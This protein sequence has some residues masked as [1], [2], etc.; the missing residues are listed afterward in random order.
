MDTDGYAKIIDMGMAKVV[1]NKTFTLCGTPEYL[2]P[3]TIL[4]RGH[5]AGADHWAFG[6][7]VFEMIAGYT[8]FARKGDLQVPK[9][10]GEDCK[11]ANADAGVAQGI[12]DMDQ[13][14]ICQNIVKQTKV[15]FPACFKEHSMEL[16][17]ELLIHDPSKRLGRRKGGVEEICK[18]RW[19][20]DIDMEEFMNKRVKAPW[21]PKIKNPT[22]TS[23]FLI[24]DTGGYSDA[25]FVE[26]SKSIW[27][28]NF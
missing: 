3:E 10:F 8:P 28:A 16:I 4:G 15:V 12:Q 14:G 11:K 18:Q 5:D 17:K 19:F 6:I 27:D 9:N 24:C 20:A 7:L 21:V 22:D 23:N 13:V 25:D 26:D 1:R 2:A